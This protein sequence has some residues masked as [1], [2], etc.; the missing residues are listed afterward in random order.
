MIKKIL[1]IVLILLAIAAIVI[2]GMKVI[3]AK[4]AKEAQ[5]PV[6]KV[7]PLVVKTI[8]LAKAPVR[9]TLPYLAQV[10]N[11]ENAVLS[12][13][14]AARVLKIKKSGQKVTKG[15]I[16][17]TLDTAE[18]HANMDAANIS[19]KNLMQTH[20]RTQALYRVK[21]ASV[22]QLQKEQSQIATLKAKVK[23]LKSQLSYATLVSPLSGVIAKSFVT[24]G[25]IA[26]PGKPLLSISADKGFSLLVRL[27]DNTDAKAI[28]FEE[29]SYQL[30]SL[31]TT[32]HGLH[33]Y[34]AII[35]GTN[36]SAGETVDVDVVLFDNKAIKLPFDAILDRDGKQ[37]VFISKKHSAVAKEVHIVQKGKEGVVVQAQLEGQKIIVAKP[38]ILLKLL[39]GIAIK[40]EE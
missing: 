14:M 11:E 5:T 25:S 7:Y 3:K 23:A 21:G 9:L 29:K 4:R 30:Q 10:E 39:S 17:A 12:A 40:V 16:L 32:F 20:Q 22:E 6:A 15:E 37:Y 18:L 28:V 38:D 13:R 31:G 33:E 8:T 2:G 35:D 24:Q 27:P 1:K 36:I 19:L 34:K 26:M